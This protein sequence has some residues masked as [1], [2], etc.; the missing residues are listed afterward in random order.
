MPA[1]WASTT[2]IEVLLNQ[3]RQSCDMLEWSR[4]DPSQRPC[5]AAAAAVRAAQQ[6]KWREPLRPAYDTMQLPPMKRTRKTAYDH[7]PTCILP[8]LADGTRPITVSKAMAVAL[9][10]DI[11]SGQGRFA[12][13]RYSSEAPHRIVRPP[14]VGRPATAYRTSSP[15]PG[16]FE[17]TLG[18]PRRPQSSPSRLRYTASR[19]QY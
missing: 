5:L 6:R 15:E 16:R 7:T 4:R 14:S 12:R 19:Q 1:V 18:D 11:I 17:L 2:P 3:S 8:R 9:A 10:D 13:G